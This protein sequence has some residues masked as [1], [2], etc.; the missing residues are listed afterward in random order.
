MVVNKE[1]RLKSRQIKKAKNPR[2]ALII[3]G[4]GN[5]SQGTSISKM[6]KNNAIFVARGTSNVGFEYLVGEIANGVSGAFNFID[7]TLT[8]YHL[9][10]TKQAKTRSGHRIMNNNAVGMEHASN[11]GNQRYT[12]ATIQAGIIMVPQILKRNPYIKTITGHSNV[13]NRPR[14]CPGKYYPWDILQKAVRLHL[15]NEGKDPNEI[16]VGTNPY[17]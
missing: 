11:N 16:Y 14:T 12:W 9:G 2:I 13:I 5:M 15:E 4:T 1:H 10:K 3:H 6:T 8:T 17:V 7:E